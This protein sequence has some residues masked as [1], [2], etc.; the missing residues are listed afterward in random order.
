MGNVMKLYTAVTE[1][2]AV[3]LEQGQSTKHSLFWVDRPMAEEADE[4][5]IWMLIEVAEPDVKAFEQPLIQGL[6]YREFELPPAL[7][8]RVPARR[9][10]S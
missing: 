10:K 2:E 9:V 4:G 3:R 1:H 6:G 7:V 8:T 5:A